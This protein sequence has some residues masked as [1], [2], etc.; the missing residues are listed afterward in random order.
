MQPLLAHSVRVAMALRMRR[1]LAG[2]HPSQV[3][4]VMA[5]CRLLLHPEDDASFGRAIKAASPSYPPW[6]EP[7]YPP[8][9]EPMPTPHGLSPRPTP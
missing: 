7:L 9:P 3:R 4:D 5:L 2:Y 1:P 6:P 8:W